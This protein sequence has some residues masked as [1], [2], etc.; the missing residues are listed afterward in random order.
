[1]QCA[2]YICVWL[3][4]ISK[5]WKGNSWGLEN[6]S[7]YVWLIYVSPWFNINHV[8]WHHLIVLEEA[9]NKSLILSF[10]PLL[11]SSCTNNF[12][13][14][15][16]WWL[17]GH[18]RER[19]GLVAEGMIGSVAKRLI[20]STTLFSSLELVAIFGLS[21]IISGRTWKSMRGKRQV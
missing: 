10:W 20:A 11:L 1:M 4:I 21:L 8:G 15:P 3:F 2:C 9:S 7:G 5:F 12:C 14:P 16:S 19:I 18:Q 13:F 6:L 17:T